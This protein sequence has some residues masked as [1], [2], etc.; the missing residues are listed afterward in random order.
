LPDPARIYFAYGSNMCAD[1]MRLRCPRS[2]PIGSV[3]LPGWRF[4]INRAGWATLRHEAAGVVHG[5]V[6]LLDAND[7]AP[8]DDYEGVAEGHYRKETIVLDGYGP[9]MLYR[10]ADDEPGVPLS[11][12]LDDI[13]AAA[14]AAAFP[15]GYIGELLTWRGARR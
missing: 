6:W 15:A 4:R 3:V 11:E 13:V 9:A 1:Q 5:I 10:A 8:L 7:E 14:R 12:Y 2:R